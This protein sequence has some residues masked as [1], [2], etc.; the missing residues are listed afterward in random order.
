MHFNTSNG[1]VNSRLERHAAG[2]R[3][4]LNQSQHSRSLLRVQCATHSPCGSPPDTRPKPP[5][6]RLIVI[7]HGAPYLASAFGLFP[8]RGRQECMRQIG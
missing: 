5:P 4:R 7:C 3:R 8:A 6:S 2:H 1:T